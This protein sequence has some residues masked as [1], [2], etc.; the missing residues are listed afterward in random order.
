MK[1]LWET[2]SEWIAVTL[3]L[4]G[5]VLLCALLIFYFFLSNGVR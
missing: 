5:L 1:C 4:A 3:G 2:V